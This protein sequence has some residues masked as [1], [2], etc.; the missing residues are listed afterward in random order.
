M[1]NKTPKQ[2]AAIATSELT[3][4]I[5]NSFPIKLDEQQT[6]HLCRI[7]AR[8]RKKTQVSKA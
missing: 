7:Q 1:T 5:R 3:D 4:P 6:K 8:P 2:T